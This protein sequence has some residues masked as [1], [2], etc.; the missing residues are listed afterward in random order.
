MSRALVAVGLS[1][2]TAPVDVR[3]KLAPQP[4]AVL[5]LLTELQDLG[6]GR[7]AV[8][9]ST[10]NRVELYAVPGPGHDAE[11][12]AR[13]LAERHGLSARRT[14]PY[15]YQHRDDAA[16]R[17][18]FRVTSSLDSMVL[19]EPQIVGQVRDAYKL[20]REHRATGPVMHRIMDHALL[21]A[22]RVRSETRIALETVSIGRAGVELARQVLGG[23]EGRAALLIGAGEHGRVVARS[24]L[25]YGLTELAVANRTFSRGA[26]VARE[27]GAAAVPLDEAGRYLERVDIVLTSTSAGRILLDRAQLSQVSRRRRFRSLVLI[28]LAVPRNIDPAIDQVDGCYRFDI[29]D[30]RQVAETGKAARLEAAR[31]AERIVDEEA[32][33]AWQWLANAELNASIGAMARHAE[34]IRRDELA[35]AAAVLEQ[36]DPDA[37]ARVEAMTKAIVKKILHAPIRTARTL[38]ADGDRHGLD[39]LVGALGPGDAA[40]ASEPPPEGAHDDDPRLDADGEDG[41]A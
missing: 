26:E 35:R 7:E 36:L 5:G 8:L 6:I 18:L 9:L 17:H 32:E 14:L 31:D 4:G 30:L 37:R 39:V 19:G 28:D 16:I 24:L 38:A 40:P 33:R 13:W 41:A 34:Q 20:A 15:L 23:L 22:K 11:A 25:D 27:F 21:V 29:D 1:H 2:H 12:V 3:E 10:C